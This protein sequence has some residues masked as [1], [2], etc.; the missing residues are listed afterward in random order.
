MVVENI[1]EYQNIEIESRDLEDLSLYPCYTASVW[2]WL[3]VPPLIIVLGSFGNVMIILILRRIASG[4]TTMFF[5][6]LAISDL[7]LL[8][9]GLF[10][11]WLQRTFSISFFSLNSVNCKVTNFVFYTAGI[12]SSWLLVSMTVQ[13]A[14]SVIWPH[15]IQV[16]CTRKRGVRIM[17]GYVG[18]VCL[19]HSHI[20]IWLDLVQRHNSTAVTCYARTF[21]Y[22]EFMSLIWSW[23]D[24]L[25]FSL[26]PFLLL[27]VSNIILVW[28][29]KTSAADVT[30]AAVK[31]KQ[32]ELRGKRVSSVTLT[33][34][35]A[36]SSFCVLSL[37]YSVYLIILPYVI[38][39]RAMYDVEFSA[40]AEL[41]VV[42]IGL[43]WYCNSA[44]NCY[45][46]CLTG[47]RFRAEFLKILC[48]GS[49][50]TPAK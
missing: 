23:V 9:S 46:Y 37:P 43:L 16:L 41:V 47:R 29:L 2:I 40:F 5:M 19:M 48:G 28:R 36:S 1:S 18:I 17:L 30:L 20:I 24:L 6:A 26:L 35:L 14:V 22:Y 44:V 31:S 25:F 15:L 45:L 10:T 32:A 42:V 4:T 7:V 12:L 33:L 13:R 21:Q 39:E 27:F 50:I 38:E 3:L 34:I 8:Y 11:E 49:T